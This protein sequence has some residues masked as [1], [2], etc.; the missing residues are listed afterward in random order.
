[1]KIK[2]LC[3][4]FLKIAAGDDSIGDDSIGD[5]STHHILQYP[6]ACEDWL[7]GYSSLLKKL[8]CINTDCERTIK[9]TKHHE[10]NM[11]YIDISQS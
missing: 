1:M 3:I 4:A 2:L 9:T 10:G 11:A 5:C 8:G 7:E 6:I